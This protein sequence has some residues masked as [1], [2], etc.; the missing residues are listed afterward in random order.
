MTVGGHRVAV[1]QSIN[2][3]LQMLEWLE[4][5]RERLPTL[6]IKGSCWKRFKLHGGGWRRDRPRLITID[7]Q[8]VNTARRLLGVQR[9]R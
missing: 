6:V 5:L 9:H 8:F 3:G 4:A 1:K 7:G 2:E